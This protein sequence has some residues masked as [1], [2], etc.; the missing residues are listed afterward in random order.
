MKGIITSNDGSLFALVRAIVEKKK[1]AINDFTKYTKEIDYA[2]IGDNYYT[3]RPPGLAFAAVVFHYLRLPVTLVSWL[4]GIFSC[5][6]VYLIAEMLVNSPS[7]SFVTALIFAFSTLNWRYSVV[8][9][10]HSL[11]TFLILAAVYCLLIGLSPVFAGIIIGLA[12]MVE[13]TNVMY[14]GGIVLSKLILGDFWSTPYLVIGFVIGIAPLFLYNKICFGSPFTTSYKHS[15]FFKWSNSPFTTFVT[16]IF[17]GITGLLFSIKNGGIFVI[18]PVLI[19]GVIGFYYLPLEFLVMFALLCLPLFL[20]ISKHKTWW[21]GDARDHRYIASMLPYLAIPL[22]LS[23]K[24]LV[25]L[26]PV[27]FLLA[28][29]SLL[30][31]MAKTAAFTVSMKDIEK[32]GAAPAVKKW[33]LFSFLR[34]K[35]ARQLSKLLLKGVFVRKSAFSSEASSSKG[36]LMEK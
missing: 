4:S 2:K 25:Y 14:L 32:I 9:F 7:I 10:I 24:N 26:R 28:V 33:N 8:F 16:P 35:Y 34:L 6:L 22:A 13:Y 30:M 3:D 17:S 36:F 29:F 20:L 5:V 12:A 15:A 19:F 18:S 1:L 23:I 21:G 27:I 31:V 11:S